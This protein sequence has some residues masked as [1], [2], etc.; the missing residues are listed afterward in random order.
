MNVRGAGENL[1]NDLVVAATD[2]LTTAQDVPCPSLRSV[3]REVGVAPSAVY[4][5]F[6]SQADLVLAVVTARSTVVH[7]GCRRRRGR[8]AT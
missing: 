6:S 7:D 8:R 4:L 1:R 3:A 2:L 5:H